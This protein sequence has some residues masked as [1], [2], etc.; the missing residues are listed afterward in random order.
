MAG[1]LSNRGD[2]A[3]SA[4]VRPDQDLYFSALANAYDPDDNPDGVLLMNVAENTLCWHELRDAFAEVAQH[5]VIPDW[6]AGYTD[7]TGHPEVR[8]AVARFMSRHLVEAQVDPD[9][10]SLH[11][12]ASAVLDLMACVLG[13][14][15]DVVAMPAPC[16][17]AYTHDIGAKAGLVRHDII[18][19][20]EPSELHDG[21]LL[22]V[23]HLAQTHETLAADGRRLR[24]VLVTSPDNPT[25]AIYDRSRL[26]ELADWCEQHQVHLVLNEIYG[27]SR[28]ETGHPAISDDY[29]DPPAFSSFG[30]V[31]AKRRSDYL[32]H[33]YAF[34]KDFGISGYRVGVMHTANQPLQGAMATLNTAHEVSNH[35]QWLISQVLEQESFVTDFVASYPQR[36]TKAYAG[37]VACLRRCEIPYVPSR[38]A[39]FVWAD[40]SEFLAAPTAEAE[41]ALWLDIYQSYGIL[42][43]PGQGFGHTKRGQFRIVYAGHSPEALSVAAD[44]L[45]R[46]VQD[47]RGTSA[48]AQPSS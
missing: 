9:D 3:A 23:G 43:T 1:G 27:L 19:H 38:G 42:L 28:I 24:M 47:R 44:R 20:H 18:T 22:S 17:P 48:G 7:P 37:V 33:V 35:T 25:G 6:T 31:V 21:P 46:F 10:L 15:G 32:H 14:P 30:R 4:E 12:G 36:L 39:V 16:Y 29:D 11:A 2:R 5:S 41:S 8:H 34:S 26:A 40:F 13:D 45:V